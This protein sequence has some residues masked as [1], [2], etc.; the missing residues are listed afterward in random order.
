MQGVG[1]LRGRGEALPQH[2]RDQLVDPLRGALL[3]EVEGLLGGEGL[4]QDHHGVHVGVLHGLQRT[5]GQVSTLHKHQHVGVASTPAET[6]TV[7][8]SSR[9][10]ENLGILDKN[11]WI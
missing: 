2:H 11:F 10:T 3:A 4:A 1:L 7:S 5:T 8:T 9:I 6:R